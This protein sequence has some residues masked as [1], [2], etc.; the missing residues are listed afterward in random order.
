VTSAGDDERDDDAQLR[1]LRAVWVSMRDEEPPER[2]LSALMS[3]ARAKAAELE[4]AA[5]PSWWQRVLASLRRPPVLALAT[6]TVVLGGAL[7]VTQRRDEMTADSTA[8][9]EPSEATSSVERKSRGHDA[10]VSGARAPGA[11]PVATESAGSAEPASAAVTIKPDLDTPVG[12]VADVEAN[13]LQRHDPRP[14][15]RPKLEAT[16]PPAKPTAMPEFAVRPDDDLSPPA[17]VGAAEPG[18]RAGRGGAA[19]SLAIA[20]DEGDVLSDAGSPQPGAGP[21]PAPKKPI[22]RTSPPPIEGE[23]RH[24]AKDS[25]KSQPTLDQLV[26]QCEAAAVRGDCAAVRSLA[27]RILT[28]S[29]AVYKRRVAPN[30]AIKRCL[31]TAAENAME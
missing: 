15:S 12:E 10:P 3:A 28:S 25:A 31:P 11:R 5:Q 17:P 7:I 13:K 1:Q 9:S 24:V 29:P 16:T 26:Q 18:P 20:Q 19:S 4:H 30:A 14:R 21:G 8:M 6:V 2:G 27:Q 22:A 23:D